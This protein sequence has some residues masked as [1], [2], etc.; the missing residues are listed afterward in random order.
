MQMIVSYHRC[1]YQETETNMI[2]SPQMRHGCAT[3]W[4]HSWRLLWS[5]E[6]ATP[7]RTAAF[8][9]L[10]ANRSRQDAHK[11]RRNRCRF[12][13]FGGDSLSPVVLSCWPVGTTTEGDTWQQPTH[14]SACEVEPRQ[15]LL[16]G[17][18]PHSSLEREGTRER[19]D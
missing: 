6:F 1:I 9:C 15:V 13:Y 5:Y 11:T 8:R 12:T 19:T 14:R 4:K 10:A 3:K 7:P 18:D 2:R 17:S 16:L